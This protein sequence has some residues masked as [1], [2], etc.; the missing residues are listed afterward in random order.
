M[1]V[2]RETRLVPSPD[3]GSIILYSRALCLR[4]RRCAGL[5]I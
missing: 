5:I 1:R 4:L 2:L 3:S